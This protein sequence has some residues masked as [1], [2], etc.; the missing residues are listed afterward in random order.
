MKRPV[1]QTEQSWKQYFPPKRWNSFTKPQGITSQTIGI[2]IALVLLSER[3]MIS[4]F[5]LGYSTTFR[6]GYKNKRRQNPRTYINN[7]PIKLRIQQSLNYPDWTRGGPDE[8]GICNTKGNSI[9]QEIY[10]TFSLRPQRNSLQCKYCTQQ[11]YYV[12]RISMVNTVGGLGSG[13]L[14][15]PP[16]NI[17]AVEAVRQ[18]W[19]RFSASPTLGV[20]VRIISGFA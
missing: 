6:S 4:I 13:A 19:K 8:P 9:V 11:R 16:D 1:F 2:F 14:S 10:T 3:N 5:L 15:H 12:T 20:S 18:D 17:L 7:P